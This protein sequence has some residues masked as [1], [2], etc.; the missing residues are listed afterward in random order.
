MLIVSASQVDDAVLSCHFERQAIGQQRLPSADCISIQSPDV[1]FVVSRSPARS[2]SGDI[3]NQHAAL[4]IPRVKT[5]NKLEVGMMR[6][7]L[8]EP[9]YAVLGHDTIAKPKPYL[10]NA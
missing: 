4:L 8:E 3:R 10:P 6:N 5:S 2:T 1:D 7:V 9:T